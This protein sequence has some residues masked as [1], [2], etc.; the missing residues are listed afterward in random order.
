MMRGRDIHWT[1]TREELAT[2]RVRTGR[3][4]DRLSVST[5]WLV[6]LALSF[7]L[8]GLIGLGLGWA[9]GWF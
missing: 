1:T 2:P 7:G 3:L 5:S 6:I 4:P 8:W 9:F